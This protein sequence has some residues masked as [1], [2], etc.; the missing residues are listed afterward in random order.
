MLELIKEMK[1]I[2]MI[3]ILLQYK[4]EL[5]KND[6]IKKINQKAQIKNLYSPKENRNSK[7]IRVKQR[8]IRTN[9]RFMN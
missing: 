7:Y 8:E 3:E 2:K 6:G 5:Q 9:K 1:R 4:L